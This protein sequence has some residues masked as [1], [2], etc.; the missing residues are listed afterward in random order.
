[1]GPWR[2]AGLGTDLRAEAR[3]CAHACW[4]AR[5]GNCR[6]AVRM[7]KTEFKDL[8]GATPSNI[9]KF[10]LTWGPSR[11]NKDGSFRRP[12]KTGRPRVVCDKEADQ[13]A[14]A[15]AGGFRSGD[16][17]RGWS[18]LAQAFQQSRALK[19]VLAKLTGNLGR[20]VSRATVMRS[21]H[22]AQPLLRKAKTEKLPVLS[23]D[24]KRRRVEVAQA[25]L[26]KPP[27]YHEQTVYIDHT[28]MNVKSATEKDARWGLKG[29]G[30]P[31]SYS[32]SHS[33]S[34]QNVAI[35]CLCGAS[36]KKGPI[37]PFPKAKHGQFKVRRCFPS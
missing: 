21:V 9:R 8:L 36:A 28:G 1:M 33:I 37:G 31:T 15:L 16:H 2:R 29:Q 17:Q 32:P 24:Q 5:K 35:G 23:A 18:T 6:L 10:M 19:S 11:V 12:P 26:D 34:S 14:A 3:L 7:F 25:L 27:E 4:R 22:R 20:P 13:C 30:R